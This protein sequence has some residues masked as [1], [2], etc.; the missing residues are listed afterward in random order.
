SDFLA[1]MSHEI[2]TPMNAVIGL[3]RLALKTTLNA[4]Q[5]DYIEKVVDAGEA[6]LGLI[7][8]ILD[9]SKIEA[10]KLSIENIRFNLDRLLARSITLSAMNAHMKGIELVTDVDS[11][12]PPVMIGDPLR[13]QQIIVNLINNAVKFTDEGLVC[14][15]MTIE[16]DFESQLLLHCA[17]IDTGIGMSEEQQGRMFKS[18]SQADESVTRKYGGTGLG[19]AISKQLCELMG[20][21]IWLESELGKG[22]IFHFTVRV[23][24]IAS[25]NKV[26]TLDKAAIAGLKVL[27][28]DDMSLAREVLVNILSDLGVKSDEADN[29]K[30]AIEMIN[31]AVAQGQPYD[32]VLMDWRMPGMDGIQT[33]LKIHQTYQDDSPHILMVSA[34]DKDEARSLVGQAPINHFLEKPVSQH[35]MLD[36]IGQMLSGNSARIVTFEDEDEEKNIEPPN[37]SDAH[38]LLVEDNAI[39]R[40]VAIG[41][42]ADT[43]VQIDIAVNGLQALEKLQCKTYDLVLMDIQMPEMDGITA[44]G[45]IR[46]SLKMTELPVIAMTAHAMAADVERSLAAGM[47]DHINKP[48]DPDVLYRTL[49]KHLTVCTNPVEPVILEA[50]NP[51]VDPSAAMHPDVSNLNETT[52]PLLYGDDE[53]LIFEQLAAIE[54]LDAQ[55]ALA[56]MKGKLHLYLGLV[57]DFDK[58]QR[59]LGDRLM[60][61]YQRQGWAELLRLVHS[62]KSNC[63]YIGAFELSRLSEQLESEL[64]FQRCDKVLLGRLAEQLIPLLAKIE[65]VFA[66]QPQHIKPQVFSVDALKQALGAI[67]P[68]LRAS[69]FAV[70]DHLPS[71]S[72]LCQNTEYDTQALEIIDLVDNIEYDKAFDNTVRLLSELEI[73]DT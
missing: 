73:I 72:Q 5:Q 53:A 60:Q 30:L 25:Q 18:F 12:I 22:S 32:M 14:I 35:A 4:R 21:R 43:H 29:G 59:Q 13:L 42:L 46:H 1:K 65:Q 52:K 36:A 54:G 45:E 6:L 44:T 66:A 47:N 11:D 48:I 61:L 23:D 63:A 26:F 70:E 69:D 10:G 3:S 15:K 56:K 28:V 9:F 58:D 55:Q 38:I 34:Y 49:L 17:V 64:M 31:T 37:F 20:G 39:N 27:V 71:L 67:L 62:L 40:Q 16:Q 51:D 41:F 24:K 57:K 68:L 2:R 8:D 33:T 7:N 50:Q 19:L